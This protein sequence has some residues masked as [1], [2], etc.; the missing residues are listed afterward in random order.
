M[1]EVKLEKKQELNDKF[2]YVKS[3]DTIL[4]EYIKENKGKDKDGKKLYGNICEDLETRAIQDSTFIDA[5]CK[6]ARKY[7]D[8]SKFERD[9]ERFLKD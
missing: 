4:A 6:I 3:L 5:L 9:L 7:I 8:F 1:T 2:F